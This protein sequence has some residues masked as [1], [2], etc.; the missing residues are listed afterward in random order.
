MPAWSARA[1]IKDGNIVTSV[2]MMRAFSALCGI[3]D[4]CSESFCFRHL[5][6][7]IVWPLY[8]FRNVDDTRRN[9]HVSVCRVICLLMTAPAIQR[10]AGALNFSICLPYA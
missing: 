3:P 2:A 4:A 5:Y 1:V 7:R 8:D 6:A 10:K 9:I